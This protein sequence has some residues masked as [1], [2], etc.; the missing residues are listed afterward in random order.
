M[1]ISKGLVQGIPLRPT[2]NKGGG[3][4]PT[5]IVLHDTAGR[6]DPT[7][8]IDWLCNPSAKASAH[9]VID[10]AG[11]VTQLLSC[12]VV[13]WHAGASVFKGRSGCNSFSVGI[14]HVNPGK[15]VAVGNSK[16]ARAWFGAEYDLAKDKVEW[17][18]T[19]HHGAGYWMHYTD[20]QIAASQQLV[21]A[22]R[23]AY[24]ITDVTTHYTISP[25]RKVDTNPLFPLG[26]FLSKTEGRKAD[27]LTVEVKDAAVF[28]QWPSFNKSNRSDI[29]ANGQKYEVKKSGT[30]FP[31][32]DEELPQEKDATGAIKLTNQLWYQLETPKGLLWVWD[33]EIKHG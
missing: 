25:G 4:H 21:S 27:I 23:E 16:K 11:R 7:S 30:F 10:R 3:L 9:F 18:E 19:P 24:P 22:I 31:E 26:Y 17:E 1:E 29:K 28:R 8:S 14:E 15:L 33:Q 20:E 2:P 12:D 6:L 32:G 13:A 5:V